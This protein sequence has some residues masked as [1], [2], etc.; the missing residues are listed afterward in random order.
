M[1]ECRHIEP[2][3]SCPQYQSPHFKCRLKNGRTKR[4]ELIL[5]LHSYIH[6][7]NSESS[8]AQVR[9]NGARAL[10]VPNYRLLCGKRENIRFPIRSNFPTDQVSGA[11][12]GRVRIRNGLFE[13]WRR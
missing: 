3:A 2:L 10:T 6:S 7:T 12:F 9:R 1:S 8:R 11:F 5:I 4:D 13:R